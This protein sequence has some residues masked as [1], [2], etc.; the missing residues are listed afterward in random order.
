M[1][2]RGGRGVHGAALFARSHSRIL[3]APLAGEN[4]LEARSAQDDANVAYP[5]RVRGRAP[6]MSGA[7]RGPTPCTAA[8]LA[9]AVLA[10]AG[11]ERQPPPAPPERVRQ[12]FH[13]NA[14]E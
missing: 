11:C 6:Q 10:F 13:L 14:Y 7:W 8:M 2:S 9:L 12:D 5:R 1:V 3:G 4:R